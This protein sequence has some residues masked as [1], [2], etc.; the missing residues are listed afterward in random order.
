MRAST[1]L[2]LSVGAFL[3]TLSCAAI[4]ENAETSEPAS[5]RA[6]PDS[7]YPEVAQLDADTPIQVMGCLDDWSWCDVAFEGNRGWL[8][9]PDIT[10]QYQGGYVPL[11]SYAPGLGVPVVSFSLDAYWGSHYHDRP[12]YGERDQWVHRTIHHQRPSGPPPSSSPPP[13]QAVR[14]ERPHGGSQ[15]ERSIRLG[16]AESSHQDAERHDGAAGHVDPR[17]PAPRPQEH[18]PQPP[19]H[20]EMNS[21]PPDRSA[22]RA[23]PQHATPDR[24]TPDH[25]APQHAAPD[26]AAPEHA[27]PDHEEARSR[28]AGHAE[29]Q[30]AEPQRAEPQH[31]P[32]E[33]K[34]EGPP[35]QQ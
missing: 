31:R 5:V 26:H 8:Y 6:G 11:Y 34:P 13:R 20:T 25:A 12:W 28:P 29:P 22:E 33:E 18:A 24:A 9:S 15:P 10:Y 21:R 16:N 3:I 4:G 1:A 32:A 23:V 27:A 19:Q 30:H 17:A 2:R 35:H 7:S 14:M